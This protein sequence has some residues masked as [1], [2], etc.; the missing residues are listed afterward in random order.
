MIP[1]PRPDGWLPSGRYASS[2]DEIKA[3][4]VDRFLLS[5]TRQRIYERWVARRRDILR[6]IPIVSEWVDGSF[7]GPD[8]DP[9]DVDVVTFVLGS[10]VDALDETDRRN[11]DGMNSFRSRF[12]PLCDAR[13]VEIRP[14]GHNERNAYLRSR[15]YWDEEWARHYELPPKGYLEVAE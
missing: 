5:L 6:V 1:A 12:A 14:D 3:A 11:L 8:R 10:D 4:Y 9:T 2:V 13:I 15:G 7:I